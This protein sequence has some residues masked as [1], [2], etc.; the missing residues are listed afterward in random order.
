[1]KVKTCNKCN[2]T[3]PVSDFSPNKKMKYGVRGECKVCCNA[4]QKERSKTRG[5]HRKIIVMHFVVA[6]GERTL[7]N[8]EG[9]SAVYTPAATTRKHE[10]TCRPCLAAI[11]NIQAAPV[12]VLE[13]RWC[14]ETKPLGMFPKAHHGVCRLCRQGRQQLLRTQS[15][16]PLLDRYAEGEPRKCCR[17]KTLKPAEDFRWRKVRNGVL[18]RVAICGSCEKEYGREKFREYQK[19]NPELLRKRVRDYRKRA[20]EAFV[21]RNKNNCKAYVDRLALPYIRKTIAL[22][23]GMTNMQQLG[24]LP[25]KLIEIKRATLLLKR[26][27]KNGRGD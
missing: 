25:E 11:A 17:C 26:A 2:K 22:S 23:V 7:C 24:E 6:E 5:Y 14:N 15:D 13:C 8:A 1:M 18:N 3:K 12:G 10:V 20:G 19:E 4:K 9:K 16:V 21:E 27:A